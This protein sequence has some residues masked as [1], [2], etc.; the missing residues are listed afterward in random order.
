MP[1]SDP[2][3][4]RRRL[5]LPAWPRWAW[6]LAGIGGAIAVLLL[7]L[8]T[9]DFGLFRGTAERRLSD[10]LGRR[11]TIGG[12][13][14]LDA[15]SFAPRLRL[16]DVRIAQPRW[17][18][19][20]DM[21]VLREAVVRVPVLEA[22][23]GRL[24]PSLLSVT[25]ARVALVHDED[26]RANWQSDEKTERKDG[27]GPDL[28]TII[29]RDVRFTLDDRRRK[30]RLSG[31]ATSDAQGV[32]VGASGTHRG[33]PAEMSLTGTP[34]I[35]G[36]ADKPWPFRIVFA[37]SL[38]RL[39]LAAT[40]ERPLDFSAFAGT[41]SASARDLK[42]LDDI[43]LIGLIDTQPIRASARLA[44]KDDRWE[45]TRARLKA[46]RSDAAG[47][48]V[49]DRQDGRAKVEARLRSA[50]FD[51]DD[52]NNDAGLAR[53][54]AARARIGD[55]IVTGTPIDLAKL[56]DLDARLSFK[57]ARLVSDKPS[58]LR[59]LDVEARLDH[60]TLTVAPII[61][62]LTHGRLEGR[63][64]VTHPEGQG[65]PLLRLDLALVG[66]R[67]EDLVDNGMVAGPLRGLVRLTGRGETIRQAVAASD[68]TVALASRGGVVS[69]TAAEMLGR[70]LGAA[71]GLMLGGAETK[72]PLRCFA[73]RFTMRDG[74]LRP[75]LFTIDSGVM[76]ADGRG[77]IDMDS[78]R[79]A[80]TL[81]GRS[82]HP[83]L[84]RLPAP[85]HVSGTLSHP[86][87]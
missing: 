37:S 36:T 17:A 56:R 72:T 73:A 49:V 25:N 15:I 66:G 54:A 46:G 27:P 39:A 80:L 30:L 23:F 51:F 20:G 24:R 41:A 7:I 70:N 32:R 67:I 60:A 1:P 71:F 65:K 79:V 14:R 76:R 63:G 8:A 85:I 78:E 68:G 38:A 12:I 55:R 21:V 83:G 43:L 42:F 61:F 31:S 34:A 33:T 48:I 35:G 18:G 57:A 10:T 40:A 52:L 47:T 53:A 4:S 82:K 29:L 77:A 6:V 16:S 64:V 75:T 44:R 11:V 45:L 69:R 62:G 50:A 19:T 13:D 81:D 3:P 28:T 59:S 87:M 9:F 58:I 26:E 22:L 74:T 5:A 2:P 84:V 86:E